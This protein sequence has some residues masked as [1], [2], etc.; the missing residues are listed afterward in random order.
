MEK[1]LSRTMI[2][3]KKWGNQIERSYKS[4]KRCLKETWCGTPNSMCAKTIIPKR[5][6]CHTTHK[7]N[8]NIFIRRIIPEK[9][10]SLYDLVK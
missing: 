6:Y 10:L 9:V 2:D 3:I 1:P 5:R 7:T 4:H 8:D